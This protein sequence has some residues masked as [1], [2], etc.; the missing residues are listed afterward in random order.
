MFTTPIITPEIEEERLKA[1]YSYDILGEG[2]EKELDNLVKL[3][4][5]I[6]NVPMAYVS[7][8]DRTQVILKSTVG[9]DAEHKTLPRAVTVCQ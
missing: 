8:V 1:L 4:A 2:L 3:A 6:A 7:F 9:I 5:Q